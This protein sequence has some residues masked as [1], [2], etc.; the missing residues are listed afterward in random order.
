MSVFIRGECACD[1]DVDSCHTPA[2]ASMLVAAQG[3]SHS[4][5]ARNQQDQPIDL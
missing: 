5:E 4:E 3:L 1:D 2:K